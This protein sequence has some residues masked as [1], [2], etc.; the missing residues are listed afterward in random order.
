MTIIRQIAYS[1]VFGLLAATTASAENHGDGDEMTFE[2]T[3]D[4]TAGETQ[5][6]KCMACHDVGE[7][8]RNKLGPEL[9]GIV[10]S[11]IA[12]VEDFDYSSA[13]AE[14]GEQGKTWTPEELS[15]FIEAPRQYASGTKMAFPGLKDEGDRHNLIA[16]LATFDA[17]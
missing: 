13:L 2:I 15:A 5:F 10:G 11:Q 9:N 17:E 6:R 14:M 7:G 16:Y 8:A 1:V 12:A 4:A 3:G